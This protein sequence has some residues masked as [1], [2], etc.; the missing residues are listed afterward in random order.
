MK[1]ESSP[2]HNSFFVIS[3]FYNIVLY[4]KQIKSVVDKERTL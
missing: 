2:L 4:E 1:R 3:K